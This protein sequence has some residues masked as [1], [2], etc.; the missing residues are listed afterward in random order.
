MRWIPSAWFGVLDMFTLRTPLKARRSPPGGGEPGPGDANPPPGVELSIIAPG[1][2]IVGDLDSEGTVRIEGRVEGT[3]RAGTA[4]VIGR[5]AVVDG[6]VRTRDAV[7]AGT[8]VGTVVAESRL[9]L[10]S[11]SSVQGDVFARRLRLEEGAAL[12][13]TVRIGDFMLSEGGPNPGAAVG[14]DPPAVA[15]GAGR[16]AH[17]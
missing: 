10:Q 9:E 1:T 12:N 8:V 17:G 15:V 14:E 6:D 5:S 3:V 11:D 13:G 16:G 7:I 4:I 2:R